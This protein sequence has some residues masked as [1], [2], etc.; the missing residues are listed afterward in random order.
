WRVRNLLFQSLNAIPNCS[1]QRLGKTLRHGYNER[2]S[3]FSLRGRHRHEISLV[4]RFASM[5]LLPIA[6]V[7]LSGFALTG[8]TL[9]FPS[10]TDGSVLALAL[11]ASVLRLLISYVLALVVGV[12]LGLVAEANP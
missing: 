12:A 5:L 9:M 10:A 1:H 7:C 8:F 11:G 2:M 6:L 3:Y 4:R